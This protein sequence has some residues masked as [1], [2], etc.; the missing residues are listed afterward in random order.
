MFRSWFACQVKIEGEDGAFEDCCIDLKTIRPVHPGQKFMAR[1]VFFNM[2]L[3]QDWLKEGRRFKLWDQRFIG[4]GE[5]IHLNELDYIYGYTFVKNLCLKKTILK[6]EAELLAFEIV[7]ALAKFVDH[8]PD[9]LSKLSKREINQLLT[10]LEDFRDK[11]KSL[12]LG[13]QVELFRP[14]ICQRDYFPREATVND[15]ISQLKLV[16]EHLSYYKTESQKGAGRRSD[17]A[18]R[19]LACR[20]W[21]IFLDYEL[22][23][24]DDKKSVF[25]WLLREIVK[26]ETGQACINA[27]SYARW[28]RRVI[29][30]VKE[31]TKR[32]HC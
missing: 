8:Q 28:A 5:V 1:I 21:N 13:Q 17:W 32:K 19:E 22:N 9:Y 31:T 16:S 29:D 26:H 30:G 12:T 23:P 25:V 6:P 3:V 14:T 24:S 10:P 7:C 4:E 11:F 2:D 27:I 15:F 20:L 18:L